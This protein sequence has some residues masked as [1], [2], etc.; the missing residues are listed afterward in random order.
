MTAFGETERMRPSDAMGLYTGNANPRLA[1][2]IGRYLG[3]ELGSSEV[4]EFANENIFV[5]IVDNVRERDV[6]LIQP[7]SRPVQK[8]IMEL[9]SL[10]GRTD[11][12]LALA[13]KT[14]FPSWGF[15]A[16]MNATTVW[17]VGGVMLA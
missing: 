1:A 15:M 10:E 4:F 3:T 9:L 14:D 11:L 16:A 8:S 6:F 13:F 12:G 5:R 2:K 17:Y 7:T